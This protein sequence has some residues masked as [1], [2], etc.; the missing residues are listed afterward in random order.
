VETLAVD[1]GRG[2]KRLAGVDSGGSAPELTASARWRHRPRSRGVDDVSRRLRF[3]FGHGQRMMPAHQPQ[4]PASPS[5]A[6]RSVRRGML[7]GTSR[8]LPLCAR[9]RHRLGGFGGEGAAIRPAEVDFWPASGGA[10][11]SSRRSICSLNN[12]AN[13]S[14]CF[15]RSVAAVAA[16]FNVGA[17]KLVSISGLPSEEDA[18]YG[19]RGIRGPTGRGSFAASAECCRCRDGRKASPMSDRTR[20]RH[21]AD[22]AA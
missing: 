11:S 4:P 12:A 8:R 3:R 5:E 10:P 20:R 17:G 1:C 15:C 13:S 2:D 9:H 19:R 6:G 22:G 14:V 18:R 7:A 16:F 21:A